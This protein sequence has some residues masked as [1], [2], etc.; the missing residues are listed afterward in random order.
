MR[1]YA[2]KVYCCIKYLPFLSIIPNSTPDRHTLQA[3]I[4]VCRHRLG[5]QNAKSLMQFVPSE[6]HL[7][8]SECIGIEFFSGNRQRSPAAINHVILPL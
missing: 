2:D 3:V 5:K 7:A 6:H 8:D 4:H 1:F